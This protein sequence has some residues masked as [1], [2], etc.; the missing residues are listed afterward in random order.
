MVARRRPRLVRFAFL[1]GWVAILLW[2]NIIGC[3]GGFTSYLGF[4]VPYETFTDYGPPFVSE[5]PWAIPVDILFAIGS[6]ALISILV[7]RC[8]R[9]QRK[10]P[11]SSEP[12]K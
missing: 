2:T 11:S 5:R 1:V 12:S 4:P 10:T 3:G 6:I 9:D 8:E 7:W